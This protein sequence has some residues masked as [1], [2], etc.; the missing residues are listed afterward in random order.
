MDRH[1][2]GHQRRRRGRHSRR[3]R[4][5]EPPTLNGAYRHEPTSRLL[6]A[7]LARLEQNLHQV[8]LPL[9]V[10]Y[11]RAARL[12]SVYGHPGDRIGIVAAG[13]PT[14]T[15]A[16][17]YAGWAWTTTHWSATGYGC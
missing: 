8:R 16:K 13:S 9:A 7:D 14:W 4:G 5:L 10:E 11:I 12:N 3:A 6:G 15:S 17:P 1:E 2:G